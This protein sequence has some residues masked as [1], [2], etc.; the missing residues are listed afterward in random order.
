[1]QRTVDEGFL[2]AAQLR[3]IVVESD[4]STLLRRLSQ[5][6]P[7]ERRTDLARS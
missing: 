7:G 4:P 2:D 5:A 3:S 6:M 1:M